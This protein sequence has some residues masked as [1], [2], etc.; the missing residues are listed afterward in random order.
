MNPTDQPLDQQLAALPKTIEPPRDLWPAIEAAIRPAHRP[1]WPLALA[2]SVVMVTVGSLYSWKLLHGSRSGLPGLPGSS[3]VTAVRLTST[4]APAELRVDAQLERLFRE[5]LQLLRPDTREKIEAN[6]RIIHDAD[7]N[8]RR[9]LEN[10]PAS[11]LLLE[12]LQ[13]NQQQEINLYT[14]IVR[15]TEPALSRS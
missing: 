5:R 2:A 4:R 8:I 13:N 9:A 15:N 10:D 7:D 12:L 1:G 14:S 3:A 11:P 6:L